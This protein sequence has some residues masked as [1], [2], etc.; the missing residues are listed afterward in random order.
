MKRALNQPT[1]KLYLYG[2]IYLREML[3]RDADTVIPQHRHKYDHLSYL[4]QGAVR[5]WRNDEL[6]GDFTAPDAIR[7]EAGAAHTFLTLT[8]N[9]IVLCLHATDAAEVELVGEHHLALE[10]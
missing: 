2:G 10:D 8:P 5:V 1:G 9:T 3:T 4:A 6:L 7:I